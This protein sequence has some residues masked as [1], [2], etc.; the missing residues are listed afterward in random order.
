MFLAGV[1]YSA[2][3]FPPCCVGRAVE[4]GA[5]TPHSTEEVAVGGQ[6]HKVFFYAGDVGESNS[7][8][9]RYVSSAPVSIQADASMLSQKFPKYA[10]IVL[11]Q[12]VLSFPLASVQ[13]VYSYAD[14]VTV[15]CPACRQVFGQRGF[16]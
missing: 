1:C 7:N 6:Q 12:R 10:S 5:I 3:T 16:V 15:L 2:E 13:Y 14:W 8:A 9:T 4:L 11:H